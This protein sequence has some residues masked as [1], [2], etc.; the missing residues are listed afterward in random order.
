MDCDECTEVC[1]LCIILGIILFRYFPSILLKSF[2]VLK[3]AESVLKAKRQIE[4]FIE[5]TF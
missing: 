3:T 5:L 2:L 4:T 1:C